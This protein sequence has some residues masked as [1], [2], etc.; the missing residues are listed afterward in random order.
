M[1][2]LCQTLLVNPF[3]F[4]ASLTY[5]GHTSVH[6]SHTHTHH[7]SQPQP[8][9]CVVV[10]DDFREGVSCRS[11]FCLNGEWRMPTSVTSTNLA[12]AVQSGLVPP[13]RTNRYVC[14][15][16][17]DPSAGSGA[18]SAPHAHVPAF[19]SPVSRYDHCFCGT[20]GRDHWNLVFFSLTDPELIQPLFLFAFFPPVPS[21]AI[22]SIAFVAII[23]VLACCFCV[24]KKCIFKKKN[25]KKGKD[26]GKNAINMMD[27]K[28]GGKT[29]VTTLSYCCLKCI[30]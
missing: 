1:W 23:L 18:N 6:A 11:I 5:H 19:I 20:F 4:T 13:V 2:T 28:D 21:W 7:R 22:V 8:V 26:K 14:H 15:F 10:A 17:M 12:E 16:S 27:V 29:E 25:K 30:Y 3:V 9:L 24:C